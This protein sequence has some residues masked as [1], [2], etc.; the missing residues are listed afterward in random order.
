MF[1]H[2]LR[3]IN[4]LPSRFHFT[5]HKLCFSSCINP[6]TS[7]SPVQQYSA[8]WDTSIIVIW[9]LCYV[10]IWDSMFREAQSK[11]LESPESLADFC[12]GGNYLVW[13]RVSTWHGPVIH[14]W[15]EHILLPTYFLGNSFWLQKHPYKLS[16]TMLV[17]VQVPSKAQ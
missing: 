6:R 15:W 14:H 9:L 7:I 3:V 11:S 5:S 1:M 8:S 16:C 4:Q 10:L 12:A 2:E 17:S 13:P